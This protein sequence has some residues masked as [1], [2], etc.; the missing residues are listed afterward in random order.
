MIATEVSKLFALTFVYAGVSGYGLML[1]KASAFEIGPRLIGGGVL[2][3]LGF[4]IWLYLLY[5]FPL[6][7]AFPLAAGSLVIASQVFGYL[8]GESVDIAHILGTLLIVAGIATMSAR[9]S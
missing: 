7:L 4:A 1:L 8:L 3:V 2:Y 9:I 6:S 5:R